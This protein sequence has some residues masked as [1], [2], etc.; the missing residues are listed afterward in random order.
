VDL[1][2]ATYSDA[3]GSE[4]TTIAN[5]RDTLRLSLRGV[6]FVGRDFDS[7]EPTG[8][9]PK[10]LQRF[11]LN[12]GCLC[13]CRIECRIPVPVH[14]R[15]KLSDGSLTVELAWRLATQRRSDSIS[16]TSG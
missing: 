1:D 6:E 2:P 14:E 16:S 5:D 15:G 12:Q 13:S 11:R 3:H 10:Q 8:A 4:T 7:L 9:P